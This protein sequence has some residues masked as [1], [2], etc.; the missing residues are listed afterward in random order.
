MEES[1]THDPEA[2]VLGEVEVHDLEHTLVVH[3]EDVVFLGNEI[4]VVINLN[5]EVWVLQELILCAIASKKVVVHG[6]DGACIFLTERGL[7]LSKVL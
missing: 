1:E 2:I 3:E 4:E 7:E 6:R 5:L